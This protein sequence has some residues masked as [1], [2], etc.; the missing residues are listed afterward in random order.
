MRDWKYICCL[1]LSKGAIVFPLMQSNVNTY[2]NSVIE[3]SFT[4]VKFMEV[5]INVYMRYSFNGWRKWLYILRKWTAKGVQSNWSKT[6]RMS[7]HLIARSRPNFWKCFLKWTTRQDTGE[8]SNAQELCPNRVDQ[9][10]CK[11]LDLQN[12]N[13]TVGTVSTEYEFIL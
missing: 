10:H 1:W 11:I 5:L 7:Q 12:P 6:R 2:A 9:D 8:A 13:F 3:S 4:L